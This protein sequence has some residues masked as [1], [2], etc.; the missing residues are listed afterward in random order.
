LVVR[1]DQGVRQF[2][3][4]FVG[5]QRDQEGGWRE[6]ITGGGTGGGTAGTGGT[7]GGTGRGARRE[8]REDWGTGGGTRGI[9]SNRV[10]PNFSDLYSRN[11]KVSDFIFPKS[12]LNFS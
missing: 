11:F 2:C 5:G 3:F 8:G 10:C 6:T 4:F 7:G 12:F 1:G 9:K